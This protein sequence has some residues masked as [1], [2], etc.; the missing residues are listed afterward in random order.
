MICLDATMWHAASFCWDSWYAP[1]GLGRWAGESSRCEDP[2]PTVGIAGRALR[3]ILPQATIYV[4]AGIHG[5]GVEGD[6]DVACRVVL[7]GICCR[8]SHFYSINW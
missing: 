7:C 4:H 6:D 5:G 3:G 2:A 8:E 1:M